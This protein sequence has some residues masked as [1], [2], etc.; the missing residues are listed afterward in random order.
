MCV[1]VTGAFATLAQSYD[2][3]VSQI[4]AKDKAL[5]QMAR[6]HGY[7][8][9]GKRFP[10]PLNLQQHVNDLF[11]AESQK[12]RIRSA[13][14]AGV[15]DHVFYTGA[16]QVTTAAPTAAT[17]AAAAAAAP[18][19]TPVPNDSQHHEPI[20]PLCDAEPAR[21]PV[22]AA[23]PVNAER[24]R[25]KRPFEPERTAQ[26]TPTPPPPPP[27]P[28][29]PSAPVTGQSDKAPVLA[30]EPSYEETA[31]E[32]LRRDEMT[33]KEAAATAPPKKKKRK[34]NNAFTR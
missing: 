32:R 15:M 18:T 3:L 6:E 34:V 20:V 21:Q 30:K 2:V 19:P 12:A 24:S 23:Q 10:P 22:P 16:V 5:L 1:H 17:A 29:A 8:Q 28:S 14:L 13:N 26:P 11:G 31:I 33:Q 9:D 27:P 4:A 7:P 25:Q